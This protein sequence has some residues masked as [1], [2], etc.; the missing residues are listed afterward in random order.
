MWLAVVEGRSA[1]TGAPHPR[2]NMHLVNEV[3][4]VLKG[5]MCDKKVLQGSLGGELQREVEKTGWCPKVAS[6]TWEWLAKLPTTHLGWIFSII[7]VS[8]IHSATMC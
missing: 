3:N 2:Y 5:C 8:D 1:R 4:N 7:P 6:G